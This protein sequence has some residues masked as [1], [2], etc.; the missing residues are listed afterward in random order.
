VSR[1]KLILHFKTGLRFFLKPFVS[2]SKFKDL[3]D[4]VDQNLNV[5]LR[6]VSPMTLASN[7]QQ[8]PT[9]NGKY[10]I[11]MYFSNE[12]CRVSETELVMDQV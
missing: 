10:K 9:M 3:K 6:E 4:I 1:G 5:S 8:L 12:M 2:G 7:V 11:L